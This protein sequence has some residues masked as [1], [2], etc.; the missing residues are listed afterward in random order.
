MGILVTGGTGFIGSS[1]VKRLVDEGLSVRVLDNNSRGNLKRL[2]S[3]L[4]EIDFINGDVTSIESCF[5]ACKDIDTL[6]HL[7]AING[8]ENFYQVPDKVLEV[9]VKGALN[10][11]E[12]ATICGV[13]NYI[14]TSSSEVY[15]ERIIEL[16]KE[17]GDVAEKIRR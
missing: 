8:T 2:D 10:T 15:Q 13:T 6:F 11:I 9:G 7:A 1:L 17:E 12:A 5:E 14:V 3:Y 4:E 16:S